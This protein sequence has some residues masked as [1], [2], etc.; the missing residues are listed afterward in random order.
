M[1]R[2][3][4]SPTSTLEPLLEPTLTSQRENACKAAVPPSTLLIL[5]L[6]VL[7]VINRASHPLLIDLSKVGSA[8]P[9]KKLSPVIGKCVLTVL[10]CNLLALRDVQGWKNG[11]RKCYAPDSMIVFGS[12]GTVYA[13]GDF[14]EMMSMSSM[15]GATYQVLLQSQLMVTAVLMWAVKGRAASQSPAQ[16]CALITASLGM[17]LFIMEQHSGQD[18]LSAGHQRRGALFVLAKVLISCFCTVKSDASLKKFR[19][20]PLYAQLSQL[21]GPWAV[22]SMLI[23]WVVDSPTVSSFGS[24]FENWDITTV[25][26]MCSGMARTVITMSLLKTLDSILKNIGEA[27]AMLVIY[28]LQVTLPFFSKT[29]ELD[30]FL[31]MLTVVMTVAIYLL[32]RRESIQTKA[33]RERHVKHM[34]EATRQC[35]HQSGTRQTSS[36]HPSP[37]FRTMSEPAL[38]Q[39]GDLSET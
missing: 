11:L 9:Y 15:D 10:V 8:Y 14:L 20:L 31:S 25:L 24:F 22:S 32:L 19:H 23:A 34:A 6:W 29:F 16:W 18:R 5:W 1:G 2:A 13:V 33:L 39:L 37:C 21:M 17:T 26:V 7:F 3:I 30:T 4:A 28:F 35:S 27:V 38:P 12:L 36:G